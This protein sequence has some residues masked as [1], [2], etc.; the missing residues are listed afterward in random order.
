MKKIIFC[1]LAIALNLNA[2]AD[3]TNA[4]QVKANKRAKFNKVLNQA[5]IIAIGAGATIGG[6]VALITTG[7]AA[8]VAAPVILS[9]GSS[10]TGAFASEVETKKGNTFFKSLAVIESAK[11]SELPLVLIDKLDKI[12]SYKSLSNAEQ[13]DLKEQIIEIVLREN[14]SKG[15][16][17]NSNGKIKPMNFNK[18]SKFIATELGY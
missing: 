13:A 12:M 18:L 1:V 10:M 7:G 5:G 8:I 11:N 17:L 16:C 9:M 15:L 4:Y 2:F 6:T 14:S 3:C